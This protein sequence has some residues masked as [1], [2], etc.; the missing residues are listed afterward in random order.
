MKT[1]NRLIFII[2]LLMPGS[3]VFS[4]QQAQYTQ[5]M[6]DKSTL[7]PAATG[8]LN[9]ISVLGGARFQWIGMKDDT[10]NVIN[11]RN[12]HLDFEMPI[13]S[14]RSGIGFSFNYGQ[15][16]FEK[17]LNFKLN[18]AYHQPIKKSSILS[19]GVSFEYLNRSVDFS[20]FFVF[21]SGDPV[22]SSQGVNSGSF[23]DL[24]AGIYYQFKKKLYAGISVS[25]MTG[26]SGK[27]GDAT[28]ENTPHYYFMFGY[29]FTLKK[30]RKRDF[31]LATGLLVQTIF[32]S[33]QYELHALL[34][35]NDKY[36]G[37]VMYRW[38]DAV[39]II[40]GMKAGNVDIGLSYDITVSP[41]ND[42]GSKGSPEFFIRYCYPVKPKIKLKGYYNTRYL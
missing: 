3:M 23:I 32:T 6:F 16:G 40:A 42:T 14:I 27:I 35:Y 37:G 12:Y 39:G 4:Q 17:D 11:P 8:S 21:D 38:D 36:W 2:V 24:G 33:T 7:N 26:A 19:F 10:N 20:R 18:Y 9:C 5:Y 34:K 13:Y 25:Q 29:D 41:L 15:T 22:L 31:V 1:L 30:D 28:Y